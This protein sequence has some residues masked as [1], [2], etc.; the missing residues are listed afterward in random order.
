[1]TK[2]LLIECQVDVRWS[3]LDAMGHVNNTKS[4]VYAEIARVQWL[5]SLD[6]FLDNSIKQGPVVL[7]I[8]NLF[9]SPIYYPDRLWIE[10][11]AGDIGNS[12]FSIIHKISSN[13]R[14][15]LFSEGKCKCVWVDFSQNQ[16]IP[17]PDKVRNKYA[18]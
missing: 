7:A 4:L 9:L 10:L 12:S 18:D 2:T 1:M 5:Q 17:V 13:D 6:V 15:R 14:K 16:P 11:F 8:D 3:D